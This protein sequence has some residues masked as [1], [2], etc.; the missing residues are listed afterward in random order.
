MKCNADIEAERLKDLD[1]GSY[2]Y[3][4]FKARLTNELK[5]DV[6]KLEYNMSGNKY[7]ADRRGGEELISFEK[8]NQKPPKPPRRKRLSLD[9]V[10]ALARWKYDNIDK[11]RRSLGKNI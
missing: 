8:I 6:I 7:F 11:I 10:L 9:K 4:W 5:L 3:C 2:Y 1:V